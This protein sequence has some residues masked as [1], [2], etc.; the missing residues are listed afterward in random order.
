MVRW[1]L[2][3]EKMADD[4]EAVLEASYRK[5]GNILSSAKSEEQSKRR[6]GDK[7]RNHSHHDR[8]V[9]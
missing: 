4:I 5:E 6:W 9:K 8:E 3:S 2:N 1:T 7:S